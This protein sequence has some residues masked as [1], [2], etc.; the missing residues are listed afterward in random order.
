MGPTRFL[1][2]GRKHVLVACLFLAAVSFPACDHHHS[3]SEPHD[4]IPD[5]EGT[6][7]GSGHFTG[8][9]PAYQEFWTDATIRLDQHH[10]DLEGTAEFRDRDGGLNHFTI[11][12]TIRSAGIDLVATKDDGG[13]D[14][15]YRGTAYFLEKGPSGAPHLAGDL[16]PEHCIGCFA[17]SFSVDA[18]TR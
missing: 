12:G 8:G 13:S 11:S 14:F 10:S 6:Y 16:V 7:I 3:P 1:D 4:E 17:V 5:V 9:D 2:G 18:A 15:P